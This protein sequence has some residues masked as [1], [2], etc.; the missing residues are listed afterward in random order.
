M[1]NRTIHT[2]R[3]TKLITAG[4]IPL[5]SNCARIRRCAGICALKYVDIVIIAHVRGGVN[6]AGAGRGK[7]SARGG[8]AAWAKQGGAPWCAAL[9]LSKKPRRVSRPQPRNKLQS[10]SAAACTSPKIL[11]AERS[12][13]L[14]AIGGQPRREA[15]CE[16]FC[17][18]RRSLLRQTEGGAPWCAAF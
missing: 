1:R 8:Y 11:L 16:P 9:N 15:E 3:I 18:R 12:V 13:E 4:C 14:S 17:R 6:R 5:P 7:F 10:F 2:A